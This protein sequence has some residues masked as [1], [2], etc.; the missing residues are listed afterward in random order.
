[1]STVAPTKPAFHTNGAKELDRAGLLHLYHELIL[2]RRSELTT[3]MLYRNRELP[4]FAHLYIGE[5]AVAVGVSAHLRRDDW[6]TSTH[7]GHGHALAKGVPPKLLLAELAAKETGCNGGRGG[8]MHVYM[9]SMGLLGTNGLV[10]G[11]I[12]SA[13]GLALSAKTRGTDQ[14][15]VAY[16]GDGATNH[17][18]FHES[19]NFAG[20]QNAPAIF[21]CENNLYATATPITMA[22]KNTNIASKSASYGFPGIRVDGNDVIAVWQAAKE[23]VERAR[24]GG[25]PTLIEALT[26]RQVGHQEGDPVI[27][28]ARTQDE[29]DAWF[30]RDPV[31]NYR[32]YL[33]ES[34][35]ATEADLK[36]IENEIDELLREATEF[37]RTSPL[38]AIS[39]A[40]DHIWAE[41]LNPDVKYVEPKDNKSE[42]KTMSWMD[43]VR[44]GIA[45][46]MRRDPHIIYFG[47]GTGDRGGSYGHTK[48][49]FKEFGGERMID[50]PISELG[51]TGASIGAS[52][53]GC[54]AVADLMLA[55][56]L[57]EAGGQIV[58]QASK[59][60]YMS[61]GQVSVPMVI[62]AG[63][64]SVKNAGPHHSGSY[65]A[66]WA[67]IPGLIVVV[68]SNPADAKG[69]FKTAL[70]ASDPVVFLEQKSLLSSKGPVPTEEYYI[71]FGKANIVREGTDLTI[72]SCGLWLHRSM[73]AA[74]KM[75]A[76]GISAEVID[77]RTIV[78]L[79]TETILTSVKKTG[80][81]LI[82]DEDYAMCGVGSEISAIVVEEAFDALDAPIGRLHTDP[83]SHPFCPILEDE[84]TASADKIVKFAKAVLDGKPLTQ[85]RAVGTIPKTGVKAIPA[86][87]GNGNGNAA[88][89]LTPAKPEPAAAVHAAAPAPHIP[90]PA[91][92]PAPAAPVAKSIPG[93]IPVVMPNMDLII[94]EATVVA[95]IKKVGDKV[96]KGEPLLEIETD[97]ATSQ[98]ES[99]ADGTLAE[100][101]QD[102]GAVVPLGQQLGTIAP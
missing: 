11:G 16:F 40:L 57:W 58:L 10:G 91:P 74:E 79:D 23:A 5:E 47:E 86:A 88:A 73:E 85:H 31:V 68:P 50:T 95:W 94:T 54:R 18:A 32:K 60:R 84:V 59:L 33:L 52:A 82:V 97:K 63:V 29:W 30:L 37:A 51:F 98:V 24:S 93:G 42:T 70:R 71:P 19:L 39:S 77:L 17:A 96:V 89:I 1:M 76:Q 99:P 34:A 61:N 100:I 41:P 87:N 75:A 35:T 21:V 49:L 53:S 78:P 14:V 27:G 90:T 66:A 62:R 65:Y 25:G 72:V 20:I 8:T 26:Y 69:L 101:I 22:T 4:G 3:Q 7:R 12:P 15:A 43:A 56:F 6:I 2:I 13:V 92:A 55:D 46:E 28:W 67:H 44:D 45:E 81:L 36:S 80:R 38:P 83:V 9:P 102:A 64:G 48:N